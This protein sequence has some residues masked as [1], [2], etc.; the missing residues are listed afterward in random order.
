[1]VVDFWAEW[2]GPCRTLGPALE[3]AVAKRDGDVEL[4]KLDT[5]RN[6]NLA[7]TFQI[8][9]IPA[10][11]AFKDA[12]VVSEFV[13]AIGPA[14]IEQ[15]LDGFVPSPA[16][17]LAEADDE[18]SLLKALELDP[19][20]AA[21]GVKLGRMLL[22]RG[23]RP[24]PGAP[25]PLQGRLRGRGARGA[26]PPGAELADG[27]RA[28]RDLLG[29]ASPPG[30][31]AIPKRALEGLQESIAADRGPR[32]P[33]SAA[34][35]DGGDLHGARRRPPAGPRAPP[36]ARGGA[37]LSRERGDALGERASVPVNVSSDPAA[38]W[39]SWRPSAPDW[40]RSSPRVCCPSSPVTCRP[41]PGCLVGEL[42]RG[43]LA[44]GAG[45]KPR[46]RGELL[47][48]LH[49]ARDS[50]RRG[51]G[52]LSRTIGTRSEKI[53]GAVIIAMGVLF[54]A[55]LFVARLNREWR[56][57][58]LMAT[59]RE[60]RAAGRWN[61]LCDRLDALHRP[62]ARGDPQRGRP[63]ELGGPRRAAAAP[64]T[65]RAWGFPSSLTA[66]AFSR[67][68]ATFAVIKRHYTAIMAVAVG[69]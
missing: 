64:C 2:C 22:A 34:Q 14:Q 61:G 13:G 3:A 29:E 8:G 33:R 68:T 60:G 48:R 49:P 32:A 41:S 44:A 21:A 11:K 45:A 4:A 53:A 27:G 56:V 23:D 24:R 15:F 19:R 31:T 63:L 52:R 16:D 51:W 40:S 37:R 39:A 50:P 28:T 36:P 55:S 17:K 66:L 67:M 65:R 12:K 26:S 42:E 7:M 62:D 47:D 10:V 54:V 20:N 46:L 25:R 30:T 69:S 59:G 18:D 6:P 5:D 9:S 57:E 43:E 38:G 35:G 1:M 58:A